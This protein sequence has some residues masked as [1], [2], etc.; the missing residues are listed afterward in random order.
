MKRPWEKIISPSKTLAENV[1]IV[2]SHSSMKA[3]V[4]FVKIVGIYGSRHQLTRKSWIPTTPSRVERAIR[5]AIEVEWSRGQ[6]DKINS[7]FGYTVSIDK[8]KP[9]NSEFIAMLADK[10][11]LELKAG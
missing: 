3:A 4:I 5:H 2:V 7:I 9:T 11:R 8:G 6:I 1:L 10:L